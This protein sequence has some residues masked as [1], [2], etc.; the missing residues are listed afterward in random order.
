MADK[1]DTG[2]GGFDIDGKTFTMDPGAQGNPNG[3]G[4]YLKKVDVSAGYIDDSG[5][6]KDISVP[7]RETLAR[8]LGDLTTGAKGS[9][10][11]SNKYPV[12]ITTI[13][14][15]SLT[16]ASGNPTRLTPLGASDNFFGTPPGSYTQQYP[17]IA[18]ELKKGKQDGTGKDG[19]ELLSSV[20]AST[21][22]ASVDY[23]PLGKY[24]TTVVDV[25]RLARTSTPGKHTYTK[26]VDPASPPRDYDAELPL[27]Q[28]TD[29]GKYNVN[30]G[31]LKLETLSQYLH[32]ATVKNRYPILSGF[33][34]TRLS[35]DNGNPVV[36]TP[37]TNGFGAAE[38]S[39]TQQYPAIAPEIRKGKQEGTVRDGNELLR[40]V[41]PKTEDNTVVDDSAIG[42]YQSAVMSINRFSAASAGK[43][44]FTDTGGGSDGGFNPSLTQQKN[45]GT[46]NVLAPG[47]TPGRM[48]SIGPLLAL[49]A[50]KELGAASAGSDPNSAGMQLGALLPGGAQIGITRVD[51][52]VLLA[53]DVINGL[54]T[55]ELDSANVLSFG[56]LS[57]GQLNNPND[58]YSGTDALGMLILSTAL[59]AGV[60]LLF[61]GLSLLLGLITPSTKRA[62]RDAQGRYSPGEYYAG[63]KAGNKAASGGIGG[64]LS[65]L[66]SLNF[67]ALLGI[68]PTN[69]PFSLALK[70]GTNAFFGIPEDA[71]LLGQLAGALSS[72][73]DSPGFNVV[74]ARAIIRSGITIVDQMKKIG[75]NIMN[76]ISA[77]LALIDVIKGSKL[78]SACNI[79]AGLGDAILTKPASWLDPDAPGTKNSAMD[80]RGDADPHASV[81]K[82]RMKGSLKLSWSSNRAAANLIMPANILAANLASGKKLGAPSPFVGFKAA[83]LVESTVT[84]PGTGRISNALALEFEKQLDASY[85][86]FY[87]H[88]IRTNEMISFHAFIASLGDSYTVA[89][90]K[91]DGFGRVEPIR[92]YKSTERKIDMSFYVVSTSPSDFD[93]MWVKINKLVTLLYPQY[94]KGKQLQDKDGNNVFTQPFSQLIGASPMIRIRLGDLI[95]SNYSLYALGRLFGMGDPKFT[96]DKKKLDEGSIA[97]LDDSETLRSLVVGLDKALS[98]PNDETYH[99][100]SGYIATLAT[101]Q[102]AGG[103]GISIPVP[104]LPLVGTKNTLKY[105]PT[106]SVFADYL[107]IK[108][109]KVHPDNPQLIIGEVQ[110]TTDP[111]ILEK[112]KANSFKEFNKQYDNPDNPYE[113][114][115]GGKYIFPASQLTPTSKNTSNLVKELSTLAS[116]LKKNEGYGV[117]VQ[118]FLS[119]DSNAVVKAF[120]D[121][122]G[123][124]MA[125]F[126]ETMAFDWYDKV[127]WEID[128]GRIAPKM[129]KITLSFAPIHDISPGI[130]H[131]GYNRGPLYP[132][133]SSGPQEK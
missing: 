104:P 37:V 7:T 4:P 78:I 100:P 112:Y 3:Y 66:S 36:L 26:D 50:G 133:G 103:G 74:V 106:L 129:C 29:K 21:D 47:I 24:Q 84:S 32:D 132:V 85:V 90:D 45:K 86:P 31:V 19:N 81:T 1:I 64:A 56:S 33:K 118:K 38:T 8:Y 9:A 115:I 42:K 34:P 87:F 124:G 130:D 121:T 105:S 46:Y 23:S 17:A 75:G 113:R 16:L 91:H 128:H 99:L 2:A 27:S 96:I 30:A 120:A 80:N 122:A 43:Q 35:D 102:E 15:R 101:D 48:A 98:S 6:P 52:Q 65:A 97:V 69:F 60:T 127:T 11:I 51:T 93:D 39:Y 95:R 114:I 12:A 131:N 57:W 22:P 53:S 83:S 40:S 10:K 70:R 14:L 63:S 18:T 59:V 119:A 20:V 116:V 44:K 125:G 94:T 123:K 49:R 72:S 73:A 117:A 89:Y 54:T 25:N 62:T 107:E 82:S 5:K 55:D 61:D 28:D 108:A 71:G 88:D 109:K 13:T 79:F 77:I 110:L 111:T 76:A 92:I 68:K 41:E 58:P 67:G 126:I